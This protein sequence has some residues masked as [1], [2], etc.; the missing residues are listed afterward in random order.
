MTA[1]MS[2][3]SAL[4]IDTHKV[5]LRLVNA[6]AS[7][8]MAQAIVDMQVGLLHTTLATKKDI[9]K[10]RTEIIASKLSVVLWV[11][12]LNIALVSLVMVIVKGLI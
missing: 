4:P 7:E 3:T 1:T 12:G 11:V 9:E 5:I 6:G 8:E 2:D 10:L